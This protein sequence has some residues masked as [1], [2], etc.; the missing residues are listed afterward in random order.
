[1]SFDFNDPS[2]PIPRGTDRY[3]PAPAP[4]PATY[5]PPNDQYYA[6]PRNA[7][8]HLSSIT[9]SYR[10][11][12]YDKRIMLHISGGHGKL[13]GKFNSEQATG[14]ILSDGQGGDEVGTGE[15]IDFTYFAEKS[16]IRNIDDRKRVRA[17]RENL[18]V[19]E[20]AVIF[21]GGQGRGFDEWFRGPK[22]VTSYTIAPW[23]VY[24]RFLLNLQK[25]WIHQRP[26][27]GYSTD[28][29]DEEGDISDSDDETVD[30]LDTMECEVIGARPAGMYQNLPQLSRR[31]QID[32]QYDT[33][34][35]RE[36]AEAKG[37]RELQSLKDLKAWEDG[38][39]PDEL[40]RLRHLMNWAERNGFTGLRQMG[41]MGNYTVTGGGQWPSLQY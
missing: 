41:M 16:S 19:V 29:G 3:V 1:M 30:G 21:H 22:L 27:T 17:E 8:I 6:P 13:A 34:G 14:Y 36:W 35:L 7:R 37:I 9:G 24:K 18:G 38:K 28:H 5:A 12:M 23:F 40:D 25:R 39:S 11:F 31:P 26:E 20:A 10:V 33:G 15:W 32:L 4:A 2:M